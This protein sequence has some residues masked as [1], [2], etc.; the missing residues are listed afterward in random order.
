MVGFPSP[1]NEPEESR[2]IRGML[3]PRLRLPLP[4]PAVHPGDVELYLM[5]T[6][7]Q[8]QGRLAADERVGDVAQPSAETLTRRIS[9]SWLESARVRVLT[10]AARALHVRRNDFGQ[11]Q[12]EMNDELMGTDGV[13]TPNYFVVRLGD[14]I[15]TETG[16]AKVNLSRL[17]TGPQWREFLNY[18]K[19]RDVHEGPSLN[20]I[21]ECPC[22]LVTLRRP[23]ALPCGHSLCRSCLMRLPC[24][25]VGVRHCPLCRAV[26]PR[27]ELHVNEPLDAFT[28]AL[29]AYDILPRPRRLGATNS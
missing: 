21:L 19:Q 29:R 18:G 13:A 26:I 27:I 16:A 11:L 24:S 6:S 23:V 9:A 4:C 3:G 15:P 20:A 14:S 2:C 17:H 12:G 8:S 1:C 10:V 5:G 22:C 25:T 7:P 28:E